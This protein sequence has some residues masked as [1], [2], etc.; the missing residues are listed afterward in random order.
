[1]W[2]SARLTAHAISSSGKIIWMRGSK[3][4][5][6]SFSRFATFATHGCVLP[7]ASGSQLND[8]IDATIEAHALLKRLVIPS[9]GRRRGVFHGKAKKVHVVIASDGA[10]A[11][12]ETCGKRS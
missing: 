5:L 4:I 9:A 8:I 1:M 11:H 7:R 2:F 3:A 12:R 6:R 10:H